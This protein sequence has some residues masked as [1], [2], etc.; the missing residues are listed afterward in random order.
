MSGPEMR[1]RR[2][3]CQETKKTEEGE[4]LDQVSPLD[5]DSFFPSVCVRVR[6]ESVS[7]VSVVEDLGEASRCRPDGTPARF[8]DSRCAILSFERCAEEEKQFLRN[9][10]EVLKKEWMPQ[11]MYGGV[12]GEFGAAICSFSKNS[13]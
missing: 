5:I 2:R 6:K 4:Q 7:T 12:S 10:A 9:A 8:A 13:P 1:G 3:L 11:R